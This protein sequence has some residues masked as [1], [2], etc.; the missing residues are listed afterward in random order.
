MVSLDDLRLEWKDVVERIS[1][2]VKGMVA[3][4]KSN[5]VVLGV[6][7][8]V[9]SAVT[10]YLMARSLGKDRVMALIMPDSEVTPNEDIEDALLVVRELGVKYEIIEISSIV[11]AFSETKIFKWGDK[12]AVGN[13]RARIRMAL[14]YFVANT[15]NLLVVGTGDRSEILLGYFTKYGDGGVDFLPIGDLYK[16]QVRWLGEYLG[17]P[18]NIVKK[19]SSP[20]L[21]E[22]Q[23]AEGE[24]GLPYEK[25]DLILHSL[26]DLRLDVKMVYSMFGE[27]AVNRVLDLHSKSAHK[28]TMPPIVRVRL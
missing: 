1:G 14:L 12:V 20:R 22:G 6:S 9:D 24:L 17:V 16:T 26:F 11:R 21:W 7:G 3:G 25:I 5:G 27:E 19:P 2:F 8:G 23:T 28:R 18:E 10:A 15:K 13:L 4:A